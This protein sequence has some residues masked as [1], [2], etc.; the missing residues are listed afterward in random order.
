M[1]DR[2][3]VMEPYYAGGPSSFSPKAV[4]VVAKWQSCAACGKERFMTMPD[5]ETLSGYLDRETGSDDI[6]V[7]MG[8][9]DNSLSDYAASLTVRE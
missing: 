9:R 3:I 1:E 5:R 6:I 2:F 8:A 7:I 4:D